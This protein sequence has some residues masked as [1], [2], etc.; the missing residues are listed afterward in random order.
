ML[1]DLFYQVCCVPI[2]FH[3][4]CTLFISPAG[5]KVRS[6]PELEKVLEMNGQVKDLSKF[7]YRSGLFVERTT[8]RKRKKPDLTHADLSMASTPFSKK[9]SNGSVKFVSNNVNSTAN[10]LDLNL[11]L[12]PN[13]ASIGLVSPRQIYWERQL[14]SM[15]SN[16]VDFDIFSN[17][18]GEFQSLLHSIVKTLQV[19]RQL[20]N[21][22]TAT[23]PEG[24]HKKKKPLKIT[25]ADIR[26]QEK[27]VIKARRELAKAM[28][29][30]EVSIHL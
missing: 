2:F 10:G 30:Y 24:N 13:G 6:K 22:K 9:L 25:K 19:E 14:Q 20:A 28:A 18:N 5:K 27:Q 29:D 26:K 4:F 17:T 21:K 3:F 1:T 15:N 12:V 8:T 7:D 23:D 16:N 11:E